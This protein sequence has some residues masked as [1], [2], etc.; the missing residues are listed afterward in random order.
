MITH[1]ITSHGIIVEPWKVIR[2]IHN[3]KLHWLTFKNIQA[4]HLWWNHINWTYLLLLSSYWMT[5]TR[6]QNYWFCSLQWVE[7]NCV[8]GSHSIGC[9]AELFDAQ[10]DRVFCHV[11][12]GRRWG[13]LTTEWDAYMFLNVSRCNFVLW[14]Q[15]TTFQGSTMM[16]CGVIA[17]AIMTWKFGQGI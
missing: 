12:G 4:S 15:W 7:S 16:P 1:T 13:S 8:F 9:H 11:L 5:I 17:C 10:V 14:I 2:W 3:A 6:A